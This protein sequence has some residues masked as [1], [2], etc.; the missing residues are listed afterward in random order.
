MLVCHASTMLPLGTTCAAAWTLRRN[1]A[2][3]V[4][5]ATA[6]WSTVRRFSLVLSIPFFPT[7]SSASSVIQLC[8]N[9]SGILP[10]GNVG[11]VGPFHENRYKRDRKRRLWYFSVNGGSRFSRDRRPDRVCCHGWPAALEPAVREGR[12]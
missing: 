6:V 12:T 1:G 7:Q 8:K 3:R 9:V 5:V 11:R 10:I 4:A 2:A